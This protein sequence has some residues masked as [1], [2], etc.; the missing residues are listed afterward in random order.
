[1]AEMNNNATAG[2]VW[3]HAAAQAIIAQRKTNARNACKTF[4]ELPA[5]ATQQ[6]KAEAI[7][8]ANKAAENLNQAILDDLYGSHM[9]EVHPMVGIIKEGKWDAYKIKAKKADD[10]VTIVSL[11]LSDP[12][13]TI[14]NV[15]DANDWLKL[16][17][18]L[19]MNAFNTNEDIDE[20]LKDF[21]ALL[22]KRVWVEMTDW[23]NA[24]P[25]QL[26]NKDKPVMTTYLEGDSYKSGNGMRDA[27]QQIV[28]A[29]AYEDKE[30][31]NA[32]KMLGW[33]VKFVERH[34]AKLGKKILT[35][36]VQNNATL[37]MLITQAMYRVLNGL[38][39]SPDGEIR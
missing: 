35:Y 28:D 9:Y 34:M 39:Y 14:V 26:S 29:I 3:D 18:H 2:K 27:L 8:K 22:M 17:E 23:N 5:T 31:V 33:D 37:L 16:P 19:N 32:I 25:T 20:M 38:K 1:M 21:S 15:N 10:K 30:G 13:E 7:A 4:N 24:T 12:T 36:G 6:E 11:S